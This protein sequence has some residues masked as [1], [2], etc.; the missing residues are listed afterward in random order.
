M[1]RA[2][3][4]L[5]CQRTLGLTYTPPIRVG[6]G[7]RCLGL[8]GLLGLWLTGNGDPCSPGGG[9]ADDS[10]SGVEQYAPTDEKG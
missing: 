10:P 6:L 9:G 1:I 2:D 4:H 8:L 3:Q 7:C 5:I